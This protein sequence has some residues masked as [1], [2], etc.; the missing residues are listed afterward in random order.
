LDNFFDDDSFFEGFRGNALP[1]TN[2]E[3]TDDSFVVSM[4]VPGVDKDKL[5]IEVNE[6][7]LTVSAEMEERTE[8]DDKNYTRKEYSY[9]SFK[10]SFALPENVKEEDIKA[11]CENGELKITLPKSEMTVKKAKQ[12]S[13]D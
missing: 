1:A 9:R 3:E 4:A 2:I 12:I 5:N 8:E 7:M 10:R 13:I 6:N 11:N